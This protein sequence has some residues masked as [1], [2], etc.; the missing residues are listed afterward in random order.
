MIARAITARCFWPPD[1]SRGYFGQE[2]LDRR[3]PDLLEGVDDPPAQLLALGDAV[4]PQR[5]PDRLL[6]GHRR[7]ERGVGVLEDHLQVACGARAA[8]AAELG[9]D[10][11]PRSGRGRR[12]RRRCWA[13]GRA[14]RGRACVL[15]LPDSRRPGRA[16]RRGRSVRLTPSTAL[17]VPA[18]AGRTGA[19]SAPPCSS[20]C[21]DRSRMSRI[22]S[23]ASSAAEISGFVGN[24]DLLLSS[25]GSYQPVGIRS[26]RP[27]SQHS[28]PLPS[29][30]AVD[31]VAG[32]RRPSS[33]PGSA[34][35]TGSPAAGRRGPAALRR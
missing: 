31:R 16:P 8:P 13:P 11:S 17:T 21:T 2:Q 35:G 5:V 30:A 34:G 24:A 7:V 28:T 29:V 4:D 32:R 27:S 6:D 3:Q 22:G 15:P 10:R 12:S 19:T 1:R 25:S 20:K 26:V 33:R 14:A 9:D 18:L 23:S